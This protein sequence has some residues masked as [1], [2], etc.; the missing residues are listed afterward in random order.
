MDK[1]FVDSLLLDGLHSGRQLTQII[2][3]LEDALGLELGLYSLDLQPLPS[4][5]RARLPGSF[6]N[7]FASSSGTEAGLRSEYFSVDPEGRRCC[8]SPIIRDGVQLGIIV[9]YAR[10]GALSREELH[11]LSVR[12]SKF[13][14]FFINAEISSSQRHSYE[15][16][17]LT[18]AVFSSNTGFDITSDAGIAEKLRCGYVFCAFLSP[19]RQIRQLRNAERDLG[20]FFHNALHIIRENVI[21]M[22]L[23][24][25]KPDGRSLP[26]PVRKELSTFAQRHKLQCGVSDCFDSLSDRDFYIR[27]ALACL[28]MAKS[29]TDIVYAGEHYCGLVFE[30]I[31]SELGTDVF[32]L[33]K[34]VQISDYD[35]TFGTEYL[36]TLRAYLSS[37]NRVTAAANEL[38]INHSTLNY[39]LKK[40]RSNFGIDVED[41]R[42]MNA[43]R[44][45]LINFDKR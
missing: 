7:A 6:E 30:R 25:L 10:D 12:L 1:P 37:G 21:L 8:V 17:L 32:L 11:S 28:D 4:N 2:S 3:E 40:L 14:A 35:Q 41:S 34:L 15:S 38:Y 39:R 20:R 33:Q 13:C 23:H 31:N 9:V 19:S 26:S 22:F 29:D 18:G 24:S 16:L 45:G 36:A 44:F 42:S 27:Q 43:L 5:A